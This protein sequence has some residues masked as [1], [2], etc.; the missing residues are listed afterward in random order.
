MPSSPIVLD[1]DERS[2]LLMALFE[3]QQFLGANLDRVKP[4]T[5]ELGDE[6]LNRHDAHK[7]NVFDGISVS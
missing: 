2:T 5:A 6:E 3:R 4:A 1:S 7:V